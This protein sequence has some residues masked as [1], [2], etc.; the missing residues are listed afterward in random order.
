MRVCFGAI[1]HQDL[2]V[3]VSTDAQSPDSENE[4]SLSLM[5]SFK[6]INTGESYLRLACS[7]FYNEQCEGMI[8]KIGDV[9]AGMSGPGDDP[10][11]PDQL[12][13][14]SEARLVSRHSLL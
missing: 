8:S 6:S 14:D 5:P 7:S 9:T 1:Y 2:R 12:P 11:H 13:V 3:S 4:L 10:L